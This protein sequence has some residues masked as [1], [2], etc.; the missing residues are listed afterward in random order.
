MYLYNHLEGCDKFFWRVYKVIKTVAGERLRNKEV[1]VVDTLQILTRL[2]R[3]EIGQEHL[4]NRQGNINTTLDLHKEELVNNA[5]NTF[6]ERQ[7]EAD[8]ELI[9]KNM[10]FVK[11]ENVQHAELVLTN[12]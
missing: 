4:K 12:G 8:K 9:L 11:T 6:I 2:R 3:L 5:C 1:E 7:N 10:Q